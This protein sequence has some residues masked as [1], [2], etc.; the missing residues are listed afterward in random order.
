MKTLDMKTLDM[1]NV[2][3]RQS[4]SDDF[5]GKTILLIVGGGIAAYK[6]LSLIRRL[7]ER[8]ARVRTILTQAGSAFVTPLSLASLS[9]EDV[10]GD[11]FSLDDGTRIGHIALARESDMVVVAPATADLMARIAHGHADDLASTTLIAT[12]APVLIAPAMNAHMWGHKATRRNVEILR[13]DGVI[14]IGPDE[15]EMACGE[16]GQGRMAEVEA[17]MAG[18]AE[19][20]HGGESR[21]L[22]GLR[23]LVTA[24]PTWEP[25]D[26]IRLLSNRASGRQG[27]AIAVEAWAM[28]ADPILVSG[29]TSLAPPPG[30]KTVPIETAQE[31]LAACEAALP[32]DI[33][34][35]TAAVTDWRIESPAARKLKKQP[36]ITHQTLQF[37]HN[38][39]ICASIAGRDGQRPQ[40]VVGFAAETENMEAN[41]KAKRVAKGCDWIVA[42]DVSSRTGAMGGN[43]NTVCVIDKNGAEHWP[44]LEKR[45]IARRLLKRI[46]SHMKDKGGYKYYGPAE[47]KRRPRN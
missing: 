46:V 7:K 25:I 5:H 40:L 9:R 38:P 21:P 27:Y 15:G 23:L 20:L 17:I 12:A 30:V 4:A 44:K 45:E 28:G 24:G 37:V 39:D 2:G 6:S 42:N 43:D 31:M 41:A 19:R 32:V 11:L 18:I 1:K 29:P 47:S 14:F 3:R 26:P 8:G 13:R 35:F 34:I 36:I 16:Y 33:G 22:A 10:F